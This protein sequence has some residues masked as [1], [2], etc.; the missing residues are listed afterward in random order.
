MDLAVAERD[1]AAVGQ[2]RDR[3]VLAV[4]LAAFFTP[5][6]RAFAHA[7]AGIESDGW[8]LESDRA[9]VRVGVTGIAHWFGYLTARVHRPGFLLRVSRG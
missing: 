5:A 3:G 6:R 9:I 4:G 7:L 2:V 1:H 8:T